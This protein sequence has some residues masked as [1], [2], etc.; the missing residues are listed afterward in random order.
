MTAR[1]I[2]THGLGTVPDFI[3]V[4]P[5]LASTQINETAEAFAVGFRSKF[6]MEYK[7]FV[8]LQ[9]SITSDDGSTGA[10]M[11]TGL[12]KRGMDETTAADRADG[13]ISTPDENTFQVGGGTDYPLFGVYRWLAIAGMGANV[14]Y[15]NAEEQKF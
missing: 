15:P 14:V 9:K 4:M 13:V 7:S 3:V 2:I 10:N 8:A 11:A 6:S 5:V 12:Y 1:Q